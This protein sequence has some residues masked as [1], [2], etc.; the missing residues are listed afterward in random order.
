MLLSVTEIELA[1]IIVLFS[2][3]LL[4]EITNT[5]SNPN[6]STITISG[7]ENKVW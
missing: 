5:N 2:V 4:R 7:K 6:T 1:I 3:F